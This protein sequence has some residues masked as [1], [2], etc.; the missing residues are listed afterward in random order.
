MAMSR[1]LEILSADVTLRDRVFQSS[2]PY[3]LVLPFGRPAFYKS[4]SSLNLQKAYEA[5][6]CGFLSICCAAEE[7]GVPRST[8]ADRVSGRV[9]SGATSGPMRYLSAVEEEELVHFLQAVPPLGMDVLG[10]IL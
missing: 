2:Q 7:F 10:K 8:L 3:R 5:V 9:L 4:Y 1:S 6:Q